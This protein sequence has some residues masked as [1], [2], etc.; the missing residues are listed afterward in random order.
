[1]NWN[2]EQKLI[3]KEAVDHVKHPSSEQIYQYSG[4]AGTGKTAVLKEIIRQIGIPL[5][6]V[7]T[8][9]YIGQ[10]ANV[11]RTRGI[12]NA[13]T[14]HSW[15]YELKEV[16]VLDENGK[17]VMDEVFNKPK[18]KMEFVPRDL[19]GIEYVI[20]DESYTFPLRMKKDVLNLGVP[21]I[22]TG[23]VNQLPP[24]MDKPAF[25]VDGKIRY[26]TQIMRQVDG[27]DIPYIADRILKGKP[28]SA[29]MYRG[30]LVVEKDDLTDDMIRNS[31]IVLCGTNRTRDYYNYHIRNDILNF[32]TRLPLQGEKIICR[33]NNWRRE[34]DGISLTNGLIGQ[35]IKAPDVESFDG[36]Q[37]YIDFKPD[38]MNTSFN[39]LGCDYDYFITDYKGRAAIKNSPYSVGEKFEF[40]YAITTHLSQGA[41]YPSGIYVHEYL[42]KDIQKNLDYTGVTRF[43]Q[44]LIYV[45]PGKKYF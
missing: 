5:S 41:Q 44:F 28:I 21:I 32:H 23:D 8:M 16:P 30:V 22:A 10:A 37:F 33:K 36:R 2:N 34:I 18:V 45:I 42:G 13:R 11:M 29:G 25:L 27:S 7:A 35:V 1:M 12:S 38:L 14:A 39:T 43:K 17:P 4:A 24:V 20:V 19:S 6:R 31:N 15:L 40:A 3:I 9:A 26:L